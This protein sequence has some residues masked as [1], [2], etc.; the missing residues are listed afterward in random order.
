[1][2][3][4]SG[5]TADDGGLPAR[6]DV[7]VSYAREDAGFVQGLN[8]ALAEHGKSVWVDVEA[9]PP[10]AEWRAEVE[11][12]IE[13]ADAFVAVISPDSLRSEVCASE[14]AHAA[15]QTRGSSPCSNARLVAHQSRRSWSRATG[16]FS[17]A[18]TTS[19]RPS[20]SCSRRWRR[21][22][23]GS[24]PTRGWAC[25]RPN[26]APTKRTAV[27]CCPAATFAKPRDGSSG[28]TA[29]RSR[30][31]HLFR[32][33]MSSPAGDHPPAADPAHGGRC[34]S[35]GNGCSGA[36]CLGAARHGD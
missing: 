6:P 7:F 29:L 25:G 27:S 19:T 35:R 14:L 23:A 20:R 13:S 26:G 8:L 15:E 21:T 32:S 22:S 10:T 33:S 12:G 16:S 4:A 36:L 1:M 34:R 5:G 28:T 30:D 2:A 24:V 3:K 31:R 11:A 17:G 18:P 9:I